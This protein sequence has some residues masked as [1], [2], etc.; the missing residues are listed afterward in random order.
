MKYIQR[1]K[2]EQDV[3]ICMLHNM[4]GG[5]IPGGWGLGLVLEVDSQLVGLNVRHGELFEATNLSSSQ[6]SL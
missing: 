2:T 1:I 5:E 6:A 3:A 4:R